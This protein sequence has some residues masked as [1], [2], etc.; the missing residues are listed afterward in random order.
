MLRSLFG[1]LLAP[2]TALASPRTYV[3][4]A[5]AKRLQEASRDAPM[6]V[7]AETNVTE[8]AIPSSVRARLRLDP[9]LSQVVNM[10]M[11]D[12]KKMRA[13]RHLQG[14]LL[15]IRKHTNSDPYKVFSD[16]INL[17]SPL[18]DTRSGRQ[19]SKVIQIPRAL[20][21]RQRR[22]R[23]IVWLL[24]TCKKRN[25]RDFAMRLSGEIQAIVNG[26][27]SVLEKKLALHKAVLV[28]R[29]NLRVQPVKTF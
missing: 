15:D 23:A 10:I 29:S 21:L 7:N 24:D 12:G 25:E 9:L 11:R 1:R 6:E 16:A 8:P 13:E 3:T 14:A 5:Q 4:R 22:R 27:S 19:G 26:H 18:M 17:V 20:N 2:T 28:N